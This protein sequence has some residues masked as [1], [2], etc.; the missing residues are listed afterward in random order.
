MWLFRKRK[1]KICNATTLDKVAGKIA[2]LGLKLQNG[3]ANAMNKTFEKMNYKRL[4]I[5]LIIFCVNCGGYSI[6]LLTTAIF[7]PASTQ[8]SIKIDPVKVP[9][10]YDK[11]GDELLT[12]DNTVSEQTFQRIQVFKQYMDSLQKTGSKDY[13]SILTARPFLMDTVLMLEQIYY[14][15]KQK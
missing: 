15:Q 5:W 7:S 4:K 3:F 1:E 10:H 11:S 6:Y 9:K 14:S 12:P 8:K 2:G 13:D